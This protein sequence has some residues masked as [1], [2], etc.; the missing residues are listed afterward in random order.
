MRLSRQLILNFCTN[1]LKKP[2]E[3]LFTAVHARLC[4]KVKIVTPTLDEVEKKYQCITKLTDTSFFFLSDQTVSLNAT[5][6]T[7]TRKTVTQLDSKA[8]IFPQTFFK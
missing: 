1:V 8:T 6:T 5:W 7:P 4:V 3:F 2:S